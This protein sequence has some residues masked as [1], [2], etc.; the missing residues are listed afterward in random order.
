MCF[1]WMIVYAVFSARFVNSI[2]VSNNELL[3]Y[4]FFFPFLRI[5][6]SNQ[7]NVG[8]FKFNVG[9]DF[10]FQCWLRE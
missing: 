8:R 6:I 2:C 5:L 10:Y 1:R 3:Y 7:I 4:G 9:I